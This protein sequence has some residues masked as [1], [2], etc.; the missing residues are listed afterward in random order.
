MVREHLGHAL[1][2]RHA[3]ALGRHVRDFH[4]RPPRGVRRQPPGQLFGDPVEVCHPAVRV[5][6]HDGVAYAPQRGR[7]PRL[8]LSQR[9]LGTRDP[10]GVPDRGLEP[11]GRERRL[12]Q[13][14]RRAG[15]HERDRGLRIA[16]PGQHDHG[17]VEP[18]TPDLFQQLQP[19]TPRQLV[20]EQDAVG[21]A[22]PR[23]RR[24]PSPHPAPRRPSQRARSRRSRAAPPCDRPHRHRRPAAGV[25]PA[26]PAGGW[27]G[28]PPAGSRGGQGSV[29]R[30]VTRYH[31]CGSHGIS[32][33]I[34]YLLSAAIRSTK[35]ANVTG[36]RR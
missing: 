15:F 13:E 22:A 17:H 3:A 12:G 20:V 21:S 34:Q 8:A 29:E 11:V 27:P 5:R 25:A 18:A 35:S 14:I 30:P 23:A 36:F 1:V 10:H 32:T 7:R 4:Q 24:A 2:Q 28:A 16:R 19:R 33:S 9:T 6:R 31:G 26:R